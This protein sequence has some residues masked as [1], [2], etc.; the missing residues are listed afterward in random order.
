VHYARRVECRRYLGTYLGEYTPVMLCY[1]AV[2]QA[3]AEAV[4]TQRRQGGAR[5]GGDAGGGWR[6]PCSR[7]GVAAAVAAQ[8]LGD[9]E[10]R[11]EGVGGD[12]HQV[13]CSCS[14]QYVIFVNGCDDE[15][16]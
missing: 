8:L 5:E 4:S 9:S 14:C 13:L 12:R 16:P 2:A 15:S 6:Q 7:P 1:E 11:E 10:E 3:Q